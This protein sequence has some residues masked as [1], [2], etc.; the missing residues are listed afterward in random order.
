MTHRQSGLT[1]FHDR[2]G[3]GGWGLCYARIVLDFEEQLERLASEGQY[4]PYSIN[5]TWHLRI[6]NIFQRKI[7]HEDTAL[8]S[9]KEQSLETPSPTPQPSSVPSVKNTK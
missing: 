7:A 3:D 2:M 1:K 8:R 9:E 4:G 6:V 5:P